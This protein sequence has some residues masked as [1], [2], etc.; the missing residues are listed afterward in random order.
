MANNARVMSSIKDFLTKLK[1]A[2][3]DIPEELAE[4]ACSMVEEVKDALNEEE[5]VED[6]EPEKPSEEDETKDEE[7]VTKENINKVVED[8]MVRVLRN[9]GLIKDS[10]MESLDELEEELKGTEDEMNE[11]EVT[12]DPEKMNDS[13]RRE[14]LREI[15]PVI[16]GVKDSK[17]RK[18]LSD[19]F[20]KA[21]KMNGSSSSNNVYSS[22]LD[23][24]RSN[25][26]DMMNEKIN[27]P[28]DVDFG[29]EIAKKYNPHYKEE[30]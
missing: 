11:E 28:S 4:D 8:S 18:I 19:S 23:M 30:K 17:Q 2:D 5:N 27:K 24:A 25:A 3:A 6:E 1:A 29:M 9:F 7:T 20:A 22:I 12:E 21:L 10:A 26:Q 13:A 15:K 14:L 16:A